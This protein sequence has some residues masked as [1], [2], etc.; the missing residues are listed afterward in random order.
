MNAI[1]EAAPPKSSL[2][3][4][5]QL[6]P[7]I[8]ALFDLVT[9]VDFKTAEIRRPLTDGE[10]DAVNR[11][12][13]SADAVLAPGASADLAISIAKM[14]AAFSSGSNTEN[15]KVTVSTYAA[16]VEGLPKWAVSRAAFAFAKGEVDG[17]NM[18]F[19]PTA[20]EFRKEVERML[21]PI[22][23]AKYRAERLAIAKPVRTSDRRISFDWRKRAGVPEP[24]APHVH[25][26]EEA[27][28]PDLSPVTVSPALSRSIGA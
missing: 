20:A 23:E 1:A 21:A 26:H 12:L 24:E 15:A 16:V 9:M 11:C 22:R 7:S 10:R 27:T 25:V 28:A 4:V 13:A 3:T 14:L 17:Q 18:R 19:A 8:G 6:S 5:E 2:A